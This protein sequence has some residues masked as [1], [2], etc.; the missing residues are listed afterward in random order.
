MEV[1]KMGRIRGWRAG[2]CASGVA[3]VVVSIAGAQTG[4]AGSGGVGAIKLDTALQPSILIVASYD[5]TATSTRAQ[6]NAIRAV[7]DE[8]LPRA[9]VRTE[10]LSPLRKEPDD[11]GPELL[12]SLTQSLRLKVGS[13][14]YDLVMAVDTL[15]MAALSGPG[16]DLVGDR[17]VVFSGLTWDEKRI[18]DAHLNAT[19]VLERID[20]GGTVELIRQLRP[21]TRTLLAMSYG[22]ALADQHRREVDEQLKAM[23]EHPEVRWAKAR[24]LEELRKEVGGLEPDSA[25]LYIA[26]REVTPDVPGPEAFRM[27]WPVPAFGVYESNLRPNLVGGRVVSPTNE[28]RAAGEIAIR[29][30]HGESPG[31]IRPVVNKSVTVLNGPEMKRWGIAAPAGAVVLSPVPPWYAPIREHWGWV[32]AACAVQLGVIGLLVVNR[33]QRRRAERE[34]Q[35]SQ[36]RYELAIKGTDDGIWDWDIPSGRIFWSSRLE[37]LLGFGPH[38]IQPDIVTWAERLHEDDRER[39]QAVLAA[40]LEKNELYDVDYRLRLKDGTY[41]WF[42]AR[43]RAI[44]DAGGK[45]VRMS[46]S[47]TDVQER[48][49]AQAALAESEARYRRIVETAREGIWVVDTAW[50]T[51]FVNAAMAEMLGYPAEEMLGRHLMDFMDERGREDCKRNMERREQGIAEQHDFCF[52]RK[53]GSELRALLSTNAITDERGVF[54]GAL[55]M[56]TDM[57]ERR[58]AEAEARAAAVMFRSTFEHAA[59]G[60]S[61]VTTDGRWVMMNDRLCAMLGYTREELLS[62]TFV[63][64]THPD[65]V[66]PNRR[67]FEA[68]IAGAGDTYSLEKRYIRKDGGVIWGMVTAALVRDER[69]KPSYFISVVQDITNR[70][71]AEAELAESRRVLEQ[72]QVVGRIGSWAWELG[73]GR[74][75]EWSEEVYRIFGLERAEFGGRVESF[76][77]CVH[78]EDL[79]RVHAA[80]TAAIAGGPA[81][82]VD[83][84][85]VRPDGEVRWVHQEAEVERDG[86]GRPVRM[87]GVVQDITERAEAQRLNEGQRR[88]LEIIASGAPLEKTIGAIVGM[89]QEQA[90]PAMASVLRLD[91]E[92]KMRTVAAP[93][94]PA[95]YSTAIDGIAIGSGV[96]S[97]GTAMQEKR[98]VVVTEIETDP[99][100]TPYKGLALEHGLRA[101]WS[102]PIVAG[103]GSVLGSLAMYF[104]EARRPTERDIGVITT[105]AHLAGIAMER[106]RTEEARERSEATNRALL[107]A[108]PDMMFRM[109]RAGRYVGYHAPDPTRLAVPPAEFMGRLMEDVLPTERAREC[110]KHLEALFTTGASQMY[111]YEVQRSEGARGWWEVRMVQG[112]EGEVLLLLRDVTDR[113]RAERRVRE[114]EERLRLLVE[115]TPLGVV[116]WDPEFRV[117]E[118]NAA[119]KK[120]FGYSEEEA[121]GKHATFIVPEPARRYVNDLL[122]GLM[123]NTGGFRGSNQNVRK[124]GTLL[125]CEWYNCPL[126]D[127]SGKVI[128][129]ASV[130]EDVTERKLTQQRQ[131]FMMAELDHR[132]KNNLAAVISLAEQTGRGSTDYKEFLDKFMGRVRAMSRMHSVLAR[133][134]W[135]GADLRTLVTQT[136]EAFGSGSSGKTSVG[137][138][139]VMLGPRAAQAMAMALNELATNATKYGAL[140]TAAGTVSVVWTVAQEGGERRLSMRWEERG[141]PAVSMPKRR[142]FGTQL[143]E[144]TIAYE[145]RGTVRTEFPATGVVCT[146]VVPLVEEIGPV[147]EEPERTPGLSP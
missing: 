24:T 109:D 46:G 12:A 73:G 88:V 134:R 94:L 35:A 34:L 102:E 67:L 66:E 71:R 126:V 36:E 55:A 5:R 100:W 17:P 85:I 147:A 96:G 58:R 57:T 42:R 50:R 114:S 95:A 117:T 99:L 44:R 62:K 108:N 142:G 97:C 68:S 91:E 10:Y 70:K 69:G 25:V 110:R 7:L 56:V 22:M 53:D 31:S 139:S 15:A 107:A 28:G 120:M 45:A 65:D 125:Y 6:E 59:V 83:H 106:S 138:E 141:G 131:D 30:L 63:N 135:Q 32:V 47:L 27:E 101:C 82:S 18:A 3:W 74:R 145:L 4:G 16:R 26:F 48:V 77:R 103:D 116:Y 118:W 132:V 133:S 143:I 39:T 72:A 80:S 14:R 23:G 136:L 87:I 61:N 144:G 33:V 137:G 129:I 84:R 140:S 21:R 19:G 130:V 86:A 52:R 127:A 123:A 2:A 76:E 41:R 13:E 119:A 79:G 104:K 64:V 89:I 92:R 49:A 37:E 122:R 38:E 81:Y 11:P 54:S 105:A 113:V 115:N 111:E 128:G 121:R 51:T 78:P 43:G 9:R 98:R 93:L 124:D 60:M 112:R 90:A 8:Y 20:G 146:M 1:P 75:L 29:V 40:H